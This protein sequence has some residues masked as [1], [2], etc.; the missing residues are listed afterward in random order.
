MGL[1]S[2]ISTDRRAL[3][4]GSV[5]AC[6]LPLATL[7]VR[8]A[9]SPT[10]Q[11]MLIVFVPAIMLS[12]AAG[13]LAA[14]LV[15]TAV[16]GAGAAYYLLPPL[17]TFAVAEAAGRVNALL[18]LCVGV[19]TSAL[20][21]SLRDA[22]NRARASEAQTRAAETL[23]RKLFVH[24]PTGIALSTADG[25]YTDANPEMCRMLQYS[26]EE[27]VGMRI[28][29]VVA[30]DEVAAVEPGLSFLQSHPQ[31]QR[32]WRFHRKDGS[33]LTADVMATAI[34]DGRLLATVRD[35]TDRRM[36]DEALRDRDAAVEANRLK[37]E[38]LANVG[39]ELRTPLTAI[40]GFTGTLLMRLPGPLTDEQAE[41]LGR[42]Q[43]SARHLLALIDDVLH[44]SRID[45]GELDLQLGPVKVDDV[46]DEVVGMLRPRAEAKGIALAVTPSNAALVAL[47][48]PTAL[49]QTLA[50][51][52]T[53]AIKF[54]EHGQIDIVARAVPIDGLPL[55]A[56][57]VIDTG[58]GIDER[59]QS[60]LFQ[61]FAQVGRART[62]VGGAGLGLYLARKLVEAQRGVLEVESRPGRGSRFTVTLE[63]SEA[64]PR[65]V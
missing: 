21:A 62:A 37:S 29:D 25:R 18:L 20:I 38:F 22:R 54:T 28:A 64:V 44:V 23:Y 7:G 5:L 56:I 55:I 27:L 14:G 49:S 2:T 9:V 8:L 35:V 52:V 16:S 60:G 17:G 57:D 34:P 1:L 36:A 65:Q 15:A 51:L 39:H 6:G 24:S 46:I 11:P 26:Q 61:R 30:P 47:A 12:A 10:E 40:I 13:G 3:M 4:L 33:V 41:Q 45:A 53:N 43:N 58:V 19:A 50:N 63:A 31:Y 42:V 48:E 32:D 59:D